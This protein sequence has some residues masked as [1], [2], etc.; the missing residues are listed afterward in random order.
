[1]PHS[2]TRAPMS[3]RSPLQPFVPPPPAAAPAPTSAEV[4]LHPCPTRLDCSHC[5]RAAEPGFDWSFVDGVYCISLS[6][7]EDR[8]AL[9]ARELHRVGLCTRTLFVRTKK[10]GTAKRGCWEAHRAVAADARARGL[11]RVLVLEDDFAFSRSV[12]PATVA[13]IGAALRRLPPDWLGFYLGHWALWAYPVGRRALRCSSLCTHAYVASER[14]LAWLVETPFERREAVARRRIGGRGLD[15]SFAALP[16]MYAFFPLVASQRL[17]AGDHMLAP[18]LRFGHPK[19]LLRDLFVRSQLREYAMAHAMGAN[20]K[21]VLAL[22]VLLLPAARAVS[23]MARR[24][25]GWRLR[26]GARPAPALQP[27]DAPRPG[28]EPAAGPFAT[29]EGI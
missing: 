18:H 26:G 10:A 13:R 15:A 6:H 2:E 14:L 21:L 16:G 27:V 22:T 23:K 12:S 20:E 29:G 8:A 4:R 3:T 19:R 17:V 1:M 24:S 5:L 28:V 7:R 25:N 9:A 11:R